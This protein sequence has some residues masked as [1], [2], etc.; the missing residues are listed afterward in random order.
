MSKTKVAI[1]IIVVA[2]IAFFAGAYLFMGDYYEAED[3]ATIP[4]TCNVLAFAVNGYLATYT[5][6]KTAEE[7]EMDAVSSWY[8]ADGMRRAQENPQIK[9]VLLSVDSS[10]GDGVAGEEIANTLKAL[11]K[12]SVA[13][14]RSVGASAA[15]WAATGADRVFASRISDVGGIGVTASYLDE[16]RKNVQ[17]GYTYVELTSTP[18]KDVG[19]PSRPLTAAEKALV[20]SDLKKIHEVFVDD[21]AANR[22]IER[23]EVAKLA[24]GLTVIGTDAL[25]Y[26][27]ID[28][29]GDFAD[30]TDYISKQIGEPVSLCWY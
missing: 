8:I 21:V 26:K 3:T 11:E 25:Q 23:G 7:L 30:A 14:I 13:V 18:Y 15:Y 19:D 6:D 9:A 4:S 22:N 20:I 2:L 12:P 29:L 27:L 28:E 10:G 1:A 24:N 17:D 5:S 16:S